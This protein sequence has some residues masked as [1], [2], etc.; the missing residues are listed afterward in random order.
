MNN[1]SNQTI[2]L[3]YTT[4]FQQL[5]RSKLTPT[6]VEKRVLE[7]QVNVCKNYVLTFVHSLEKN[8]Y[9][10][11]KKYSESYLTWDPEYY[12]KEAEKRKDMLTQ[13][14]TTIQKTSSKDFLSKDFSTTNSDL[15][16]LYPNH[17]PKSSVRE[18]YQEQWEKLKEKHD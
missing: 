1:T 16:T 5:V 18:F 15:D 8:I 9:D 17:F 2:D 6:Y 4:I 10:D 13:F 12:K 11:L 7:E 14:S 3:L